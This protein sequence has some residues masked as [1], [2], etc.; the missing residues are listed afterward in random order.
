M[1]D[2]RDMVDFL[3]DLSDRQYRWLMRGVGATFIAGLLS[4]TRK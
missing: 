3:S 1:K 2:E 4:L